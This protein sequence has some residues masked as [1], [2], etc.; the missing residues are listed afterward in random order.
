MAQNST[1]QQCLS[2]IAIIDWAMLETALAIGAI[3]RAAT[4]LRQYKKMDIQPTIPE[5]VTDIGLRGSPNYELLRILSPKLIIA[6]NFYEY[7]RDTLEKIAPVFAPIVFGQGLLPR[8]TLT[9]ATLELGQQLGCAR[10]TEIFIKNYDSFIQQKRG[11]FSKL[12]Q[13]DYFIINLGNGRNFRAFGND[14]IFG[15]ALK[16]VGLNNAWNSDTSYSAYA[17]IGLEELALKP[18]AGIIIIGP[19]EE[20]TLHSLPDNQL[21]NVLPAIKQSNFLFLPALN[22]FGG[23]P[24][25]QYFISLLSKHWLEADNE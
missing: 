2:D 24:T 20:E 3:P 19:T 4:E 11:D 9:K 18:D 7:Q 16:D 22:H 25:A 12:K 15:A 13:R 23:L 14:S 6:S 5:S 17:H 8:P 10:K 21:W 1:L